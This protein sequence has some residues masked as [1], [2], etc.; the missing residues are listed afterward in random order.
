MGNRDDQF[1]ED[2]AIR[3]AD[4]TDTVLWVLMAVMAALVVGGLAYGLAY[5]S[6]YASDSVKKVGAVAMQGPMDRS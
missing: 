4:R 2:G 6:L 5:P 3:E 1:G